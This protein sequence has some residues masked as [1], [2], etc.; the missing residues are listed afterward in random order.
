MSLQDTPQ[1]PKASTPPARSVL[2]SRLNNAEHLTFTIAESAVLLGISKS[3]A[4]HAYRRTGYLTDGVRVLRIGKRCVVSAAELRRALG[5][6][7]P[8]AE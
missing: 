5:M 8:I 6:G 2:V 4:S 1:K 3:T 7:E